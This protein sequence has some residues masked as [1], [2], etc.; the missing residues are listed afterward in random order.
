MSRIEKECATSDTLRCD[1]VSL[2]NGGVYDLYTYKR[3][4]DVRLVFAPEL[5]IA[6]FG[7]DPDNFMFPRHALDSAFLRVYEGGKPAKVKNFFKW[8][9]SG[10][11]EGELTF[12]AGNPGST[13]RLKTIA[14]TIAFRDFGLVRRL[15]YLSEMR[16]E[17]VQ[18]AKRGA[19]Q[20]RH[21]K[22]MLF[23]VENGLK[24]YK[25]EADALFA[26]GFIDALKAKED[27][28]RAKVMADKELAAKFGGAWDAI[29]EAVQR[30]RA[31]S[32][33]LGMLES[34]QA[35]R[36]DLFG[37][38]RML[39]RAAAE[40]PKPN[41]ERLREFTE[42]RKPGLEAQLM[43][44]A[45]I[46]PEFDIFRLTFGLTK[47]REVLGP[48][49]AT[50]KRVLGS[51]SPEQLATRLVEGSKLSDPAVRKALYQGG[52]AAI[53]ASEDPLI[54][55]A[56]LVDD[57]SRALRRQYEDEIEAVIRK[58]HEL[59]AA[60]RFITEGTNTYPD[61]TFSPRVSY[62]TV[63]GWQEGE[64]TIKPYTTFGSTFERHTGADP[65]ALPKSWPH[66][67]RSTTP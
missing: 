8:S 3:H 43:S 37:F 34:G 29:A 10:T 57:E 52:A 24:A 35:F 27:A 45:P 5:A 48:D 7:G 39:V 20:A 33:R 28:L 32:V 65:F 63:M 51:E 22:S 67:R 46:Y 36:S 15:M 25:G 60:A 12:T 64:K 6:F 41:E 58:N 53:D 11:K 66:V 42:G 13:S 18:Y 59:I 50:V 54:M 16:G 40:F 26:P 49:D 9:K 55:L 47:F 30:S 62:G 4:Q 44:P 14:E 17:L 19:E 38:A 23:G 2:Y 61:A 21:S 31:L 56:K 1:I